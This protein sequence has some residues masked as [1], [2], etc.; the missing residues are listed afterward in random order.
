MFE[1]RGV[2][3]H[4]SLSA[5]DGTH[6]LSDDPDTSSISTIINTTKTTVYTLDAHLNASCVEEIVSNDN[7]SSMIANKLKS[8][9]SKMLYGMGEQHIDN[10]WLDLPDHSKVKSA[11]ELADTPTKAYHCM[12]MYMLNPI[13][14]KIS[15]KKPVELLDELYDMDFNLV[16]LIMSQ[17][18]KEIAEKFN[19]KYNTNF[20]VSDAL[21]MY[22]Y[23]KFEEGYGKIAACNEIHLSLFGEN[24]Y[25]DDW[26]FE[27]SL[28][29]LVHHPR[30]QFDRESFDSDLPQFIRIENRDL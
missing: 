25:N 23:V 27:Q 8:L 21:E 29:D 14:R 16:H 4:P 5:D 2:T 28:I 22:E 18:S 17:Q 9:K 10:T 19:I 1:A 15:N 11:L 24:D 30:N 26:S 13:F 12:I 20:S 7:N 6:N 3:S